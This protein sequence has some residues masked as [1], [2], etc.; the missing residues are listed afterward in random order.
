MKELLQK[1]LFVPRRNLAVFSVFKQTYNIKVT[2]KKLT[3][4][5]NGSKSL[6]NDLANKMLSLLPELKLFLFA[7]V[8]SLI[9]F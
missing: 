4:M 3:L 8:R 7:D 2:K 9:F 1:R 5:S 6:Q